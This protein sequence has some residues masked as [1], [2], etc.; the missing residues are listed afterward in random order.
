MNR[1]RIMLLRHRV[2]LLAVLGAAASARG[3]TVARSK[4]APF[5]AVVVIDY[6]RGR[7]T[8]AASLSKSR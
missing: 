8:G 4:S 7:R 6:V 1:E 2:T 3:T 5:S